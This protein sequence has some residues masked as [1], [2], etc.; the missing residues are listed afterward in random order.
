MS[1]EDD[2]KYLKLAVN[3]VKKSVKLGGFP[4]G[5][6]LVKNNQVIGRTSALG[7]KL[8]DPTSH[9]EIAIIRKTCKKLKTT[10]LSDCTLYVSMESCLMCFMADSFANIPRIVYACR[11][12]LV[13]PAYYGSSIDIHEINKTL[14]RSIGLIFLPDFESQVLQ[15]IKDWEDKKS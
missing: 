15:I 13:S 3:Q 6:V 8:H 2:L 11:R 5:A 10:D 7:N 14:P 9:P 12:S 4:A 1:T